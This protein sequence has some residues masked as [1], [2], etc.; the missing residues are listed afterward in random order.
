MIIVQ[1]TQILFD[2]NKFGVHASLAEDS[3]HSKESGEKEEQVN[4]APCIF[5]GANHHEKN[6]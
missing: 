2:Q 1:T 5:T 3:Q 4:W 6:V